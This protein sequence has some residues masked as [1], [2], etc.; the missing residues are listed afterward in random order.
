[1]KRKEDEK[2]KNKILNLT[3]LSKIQRKNSNKK[4][5]KKEAQKKYEINSMNRT[6]KECKLYNLKDF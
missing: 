5:H 3:Q 2:N 4:Q 1:M 6:L